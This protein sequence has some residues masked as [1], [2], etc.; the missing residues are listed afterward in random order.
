MRLTNNYR[1]QIIKK[2]IQARFADAES[3]YATACTALADA[4]YD[5]AF[6]ADEILAKRLPDGWIART[7]QII[8]SCEGFRSLYSS[9]E[10]QPKR[11]LKL[12]R[13]RPIPAIVRDQF[14]VDKSHSLYPQA[15]ALIKMHEAI[16]TGKDQLTT[17]LRS[18]LFSVQTIERLKE[19]WPEGEPYFPFVP[20]K[21]ALPVPYELT[22]S[23][24]RMM[25]IAAREGATA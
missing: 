12:S 3:Q 20:E 13:S 21:S 2:C 11:E 24:N 6:G 5:H 22:L 17:Q 4:M 7:T 8:I 25:G 19:I 9:S 23:I 14:K 1:D 18:L 15:Q 16:R 10:E